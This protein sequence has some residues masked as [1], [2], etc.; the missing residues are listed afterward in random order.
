MGF[1]LSSTVFPLTL[2]GSD[3]TNRQHTVMSS[4][5]TRNGGSMMRR[6]SAVGM[7]NFVYRYRF[8]GLPNGISMPPRF[9]AIFCIIN[10]NGRYF[11]LPVDDRTK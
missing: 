8:C 2:S 1:G 10:V 4:I 11:S 6:N 3:L 5:D 9:A 7:P